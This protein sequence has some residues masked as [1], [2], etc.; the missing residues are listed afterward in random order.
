MRLAFSNC[1]DWGCVW[2]RF[3]LCR[4]QPEKMNCHN[5]IDLQLCYSK[6]SL[7]EYHTRILILPSGTMPRFTL[8]KSTVVC[9]CV[10]SV[11]IYL[12]LWHTGRPVCRNYKGRNQ[13]DIRHIFVVTCNHAESSSRKDNPEESSDEIPV[14]SVRILSVFACLAGISRKVFT[15]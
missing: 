10:F 5:I 12:E 9:R 2:V 13:A 8:C 15:E 7:K 11:F 3:A 4:G 6:Y 1:K 14:K